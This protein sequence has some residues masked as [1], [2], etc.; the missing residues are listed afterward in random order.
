LRFQKPKKKQ[1]TKKKF[2]PANALPFAIKREPG[3]R[4]CFSRVVI[5]LSNGFLVR[6]KRLEVPVFYFLL[7]IAGNHFEQLSL[8]QAQGPLC[9]KTKRETLCQRNGVI[10]P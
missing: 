1:K 6:K 3:G 7:L 9:D 5:H 8:D 10:F 2:S 4:S